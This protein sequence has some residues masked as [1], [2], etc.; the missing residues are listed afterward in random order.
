MIVAELDPAFVVTHDDD[1]VLFREL[2]ASWVQS[3]ELAAALDFS[4]TCYI[5]H[6]DQSAAH[7]TLSQII[8]PRQMRERAACVERML[9]D[10]LANGWRLSVVLREIARAWR[11][12][13]DGQ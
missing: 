1:P 7:R 4:L 2:P 11:D 12:G 3:F 9:L 5:Q 8:A 13:E 10:R 6:V